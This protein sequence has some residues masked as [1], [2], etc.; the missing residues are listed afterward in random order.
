MPFKFADDTDAR[1]NGSVEISPD[2][3]SKL[4]ATVLSEQIPAMVQEAV[5]EALHI[6]QPGGVKVC[7]L[8]GRIVD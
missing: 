7:K 4:I 6:K 5:D 1:G 2:E 8:T 3:F